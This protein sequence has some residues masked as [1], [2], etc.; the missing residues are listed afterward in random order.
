V[1][2]SKLE[3]FLIVLPI[4]IGSLTLHELAHG[5]VAYRLGDP[6]AK[7]LGRLSLNPIVHL[8]P[9][10]SLMF[11]ASY[12][13]GGFLFGWARPV[14]VDPRNL[15]LGP[16]R[17][18][19]LVGIAGPITNFLLALA[20]GAVIAHTDYS[21]TTLDVLVYA[22]YVNIVLGVFNLLPIPPLDGSRIIG[23][24]MDR[25]TYAAWS[26]LDQYGMVILLVCFFVFQ[27]QFT[28]L[29]HSSTVKVSTVISDIVGGTPFSLGAA[30]LG[31]L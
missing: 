3:V 16:Q 2:D 20:F 11:V 19:A 31:A 18:M 15:R 25:Q 29:L 28:T 17:G 10:G 9:L 6:T 21:G 4:F 8:E 23:G 30:V 7:L 26:A 14:P 22:M 24:F 12:W 13:A 27:G 1:G 5:L